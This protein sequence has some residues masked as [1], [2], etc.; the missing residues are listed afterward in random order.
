MSTTFVKIVWILSVNLALYLAQKWPRTWQALAWMKALRKL[1]CK[2][3]CPGF[4]S[5]GKAY[6]LRHCFPLPLRPSILAIS[7]CLTNLTGSSACM[8][9]IPWT[10]RPAFILC[11]VLHFVNFVSL[12]T[13]DNL[14]SSSFHKS[15]TFGTFWS[16]FQPLAQIRPLSQRYLF[17][18]FLSFR[19]VQM[20]RVSFDDCL[21][22]EARFQAAD[23]QLTSFWIEL[24]LIIDGILTPITYYIMN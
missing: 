11:I 17:H 6:L 21:E 24:C 4:G 16:S 12:F 22:R 8:A 9:F 19:Q 23:H 13:T 2:D 5:I 15:S 18:V 1:L 7:T 14:S 20:M 3:L 10:P